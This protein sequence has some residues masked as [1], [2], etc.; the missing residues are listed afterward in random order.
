[1][2]K[3]MGSHYLIGRKHARQVEVQRPLLLR[4]MAARQAELDRLESDYTGRLRELAAFMA[5]HGEKTWQMMRG[6]ADGLGLEWAAMQ[7]YTFSSYLLD[8]HRAASAPDG[9]TTFAASGPVTRDGAPLLAKN[10]DYRRD[11]L[12]L[13]ILTRTR[14]TRGYRYVHLGSAGSPGVFSSGMNE[15]GLA[16]ADTHVVS[17]DLGPGLPRYALMLDLLEQCPDVPA[18]LDYLRGA[19][20]MGGGTII[21]ADEDGRLAVCESG[22][23]S[24]GY[25]VHN[26]GW[27]V[28]TNHFTT[29]ELCDQWVESAGFGRDG[30]SQARRATAGQ[31]LAQS[32][33]QVD[34]AWAQALLSHHRDGPGS[35]CQHERPGSR[36]ATILSAIFLPRSRQLVVGT[37]NPCT[38]HWI[39][40]S[41]IFTD[42]N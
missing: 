22:H 4:A 7:R 8:L 42:G 11:H 41:N 15:R 10:R 29:P 34:V 2:L 38:T 18:A 1:M 3:I 16:V 33:G 32:D 36:T 14:P 25:V 31:A 21:M 27:L 40:L 20:H 35:L 39:S 28:S 6:I 9:C 30:N 19:T 12:G 37:G 17:R 23:R 26:E 13:Q 24:S 5:E